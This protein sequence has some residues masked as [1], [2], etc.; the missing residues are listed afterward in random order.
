MF[1]NQLTTKFFWLIAVTTRILIRI[2]TIKGITKIVLEI[3]L[4]I[5]H[6][7]IL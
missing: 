6:I 3:I 7:I 5:K 4:R 2:A 1:L